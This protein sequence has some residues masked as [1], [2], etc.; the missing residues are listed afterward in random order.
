MAALASALSVS[1]VASA[2]TGFLYGGMHPINPNFGGGFCYTNAAHD[3]PYPSDPNVSYLYR[4]WNGYQYFVGNPY[5]FGYQ[6]QAF[7]YYGHHPLPEYSSYCY[8]DGQ[9]HHHFLPPAGY[10]ASYVVNN[11]YYYYNGVF[12]PYYYSYRPSYYRARHTYYY[13]P[14]YRSYYRS[15][16]STWRR[17]HTPASVTYITR[18]PAFVPR[19]TSPPVRTHIVRTYNAPAYRYNTARPNSYNYN[20]NRG[21]TR[22]TTTTTSYRPRGGTVVTRTR[23]WRR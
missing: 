13:L 10:A 18:R 8:I 15:Y 16:R 17:Y 5:H 9:H 4:N 14:T 22:V 23:S 1:S 20:Y 11:G 2:Q 6:G 19:Y 12:A 3:H 21:A 7:P